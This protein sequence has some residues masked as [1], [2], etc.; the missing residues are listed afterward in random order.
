MRRCAIA[1]PC[2]GWAQVSR[3][4]ACL[5]FLSCLIAVP[6]ARAATGNGMLAYEA[7]S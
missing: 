3:W 7:N 6:A 5:V 4:L 1:L 2:V